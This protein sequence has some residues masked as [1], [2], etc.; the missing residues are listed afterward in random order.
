MAIPYE[1]RRQIRHWVIPVRDVGV[2]AAE[3]LQVS[4]REECWVSR[5][6]GESGPGESH[7]CQQLSEPYL[8][9]DEFGKR[10]ISASWGS[11][12][13]RVDRDGRVKMLAEHES[14][15]DRNR[16]AKAVPRDED[17]PGPRVL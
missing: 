4:Y 1:S 11:E 8:R 6:T 12:D 3:L 15:Q 16:R 14:V 5:A 9:V 2:L 7:N 10:L 13:N 17:V